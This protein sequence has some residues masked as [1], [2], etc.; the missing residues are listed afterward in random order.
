MASP[1]QRSFDAL[2][3]Y[4]T[5]LNHTP[6]VLLGTRVFS[7]V[8]TFPNGKKEHHGTFFLGFTFTLITFVMYDMK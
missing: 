2:N 3:E 5:Q 6:I 1:K 7:D 8:R 4:N